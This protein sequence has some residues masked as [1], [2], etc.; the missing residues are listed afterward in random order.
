MAIIVGQP[1][2]CICRQKIEK[3]EAWTATSGAAFGPPHP[4]YPFCDAPL[5]FSCLEV[6]P[7]REEFSRG[8]FEGALQYYES[9]WSGVVADMP[10]L[11]GTIPPY[12]LAAGSQWFLCC[13][14]SRHGEKPHYAEIVLAHWPVVL[15]LDDWH[16]WESFL[17]AGF[18]A[19][20]AGQCLLDAE[21]VMREVH[22]VASSQVMLDR[23]YDRAQDV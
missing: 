13:G 15:R 1:K 4:L 19:G 11:A 16:E 8:Y 5:H 6:W 9:G 2:C 7:Y 17:V 10:Q 3:G 21:A 20:L 18:K 23:L 14:P 22:E 12:R